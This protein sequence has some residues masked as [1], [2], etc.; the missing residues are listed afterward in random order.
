MDWEKANHFLEKSDDDRKRAF[1]GFDGYIDT[2]SKLLSD[3]RSPLVTLKDFGDLLIGRDNR[4]ASL[5]LSRK[6]RKIGGNMPITAHALGTLGVSVDCVGAFGKPDIAKEFL[7]MDPHCSLYSLADPGEC[8]A[9]EFQGSKL[10]LA[11]H[12]EV[13]ALTWQEM[14]R[15]IGKETMTQLIT[16]AAVIVLV[17]WG[18]LPNMQKI[19]GSLYTEIVTEL[20]DTGRSFF[21]DLS[22]CS[23]RHPDE[24]YEVMLM[25][26][27]FRKYGKVILSVNDNELIT[28]ANIYKDKK[29]SNEYDEAFVSVNEKDLHKHHKS[30]DAQENIFGKLIFNTGF[31]DVLI[32]HGKH[33]VHIYSSAGSQSVM[34]N[35][36]LEPVILTGGGDHFNA[37]FIFGLMADYPLLQCAEI[38][39]AVSHAYV[40][41]GESPAFDQLIKDV[42]QHSI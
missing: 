33:Y 16:G 15:T 42:K 31:I 25:I 4:N 6:Y 17:N 9:I 8:I 1:I 27:K 20:S 21:F 12:G 2:V 13:A 7:E 10:F 34:G 22:D 11:D 39:N 41:R 40:K 28:L 32:H 29:Q 36:V 5:T 35:S 37:G 18:E 23:G 38:G 30:F 24:L 26:S 19:W 14:I 3:S